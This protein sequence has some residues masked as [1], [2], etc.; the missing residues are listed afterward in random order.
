MAVGGTGDEFSPEA[1]HLVFTKTGGVPRLV[2]QL[3][4]LAMVYAWSSETRAVT[5][6][7]VRNVIEDGLFH[8]GELAAGAV[9]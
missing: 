3:C 7:T 5:D 4:D 9:A 6:A 2:N 8:Y 1:A